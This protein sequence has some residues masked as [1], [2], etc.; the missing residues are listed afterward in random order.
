MTSNLD[1]TI[2]VVPRERFSYARRSLSSVFE[3]TATPFKLI[4]V[5]PGTPSII[6]KYLQ[7]E[8]EQKKFRLLSRDGYISPNRARNWAWQ[9]VQTKYTVF[10]DNDAL[11]TPGWLEELVRCA[12]ETGAWVVG[13]LYLI[14]EIQQRRI[15]LAGGRLHEKQEHGKKMLYDEQYLFDTPLD[16]LQVPLERK[17]WDYAEFHCMLVRTDVL[18][19]IGPLDEELTSLHEHIDLGLSVRKAGGTVFIEPKALTSYVP[20]PPGEWWDLPYF[21]LRWSE[22]WNLASV[23]HINHKWGYSGLGWLGDKKPPSGDEDTIIRFGRGHRRLMTGL[24]PNS[25]DLMSVLPIEQA[26][27]MVALLLSVDRDRFDLRLVN[28][29]ANVIASET[30]LDPQGVFEKLRQFFLRAEQ[31]RLGVLIQPLGPR[32]P[33]N[34]ALVR[35]DGLDSVAANKI[36][37]YSFLTLEVRPQLYQSWVAV[38]RANWRSAEKLIALFGNSETMSPAPVAGSTD[39]NNHRVR[40]VEGLAGMLV[41]GNQLDRGELQP[42]FKSTQVI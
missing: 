18:E 6:R 33:E 38:D 7:E 35:F 12:D 17:A 26:E 13:P 23:R 24:R 16:N 15:H 28:S 1:V 27:L 5:D 11:V 31:E 32:R 25:D 29:D 19:R 14:G 3:N 2:V 9:E 42:Y 30:G 40:L 4:Y 34:P 39:S 41:T 21:M 36:R 8:S 37:P 22:E 20:P 10:L